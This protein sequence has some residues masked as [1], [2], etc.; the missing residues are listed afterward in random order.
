MAGCVLEQQRSLRRF[1]VEDQRPTVPAGALG[2]DAKVGDDIVAE[3]PEVGGELRHLLLLLWYV[4]PRSPMQ[5]SSA[6]LIWPWDHTQ[7][8]WLG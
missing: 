3:R 2:A 1:D 5:T 8:C 7:E 4:T 6:S